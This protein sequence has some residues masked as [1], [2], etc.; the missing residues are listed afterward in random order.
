LELEPLWIRYVLRDCKEITVALDWTSFHEDGQSMLSLNSVTS[1]GM[2]TPL[3]WKSAEN[4]RIKHNRARYEDDLLSRF[5]EALPPDI[6]V[7]LL[8]DRGFADQKFFKFLDEEL[9]FNYIIRIKSITTIAHADKQLKAKDWLATD[10][11][12]LGLKNP[13][14]TLNAYPV[15]QFV[16]VQDKGM[17]APWF[18]VSNCCLTSRKTVQ[19][20]AK[21]WKIEPYFR[22]LKNGRYGL[23]LEQTHLKSCERRDRLMLVL[24]F[25][26]NLLVVLGQAGEQLNFDRKLKVNTVKKRTHSLFNQGLFYYQ[27]F[28]RFTLEEQLLLMDRFDTLLQLRG[29]WTD[30]LESQ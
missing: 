8:A 16:A 27:C 14:I 28:Y 7:T 12:L 29:F 11:A 2:S 4:S 17:K 26:Y 15:E 10:G 19:A 20:Y 21:R 3:I 25:S 1:K 23:G 22:D 13:T 6:K 24:A 18:L 9:K 30:L 5:K